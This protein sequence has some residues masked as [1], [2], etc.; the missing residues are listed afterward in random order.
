[1]PVFTPK[2]PRDQR[3]LLERDDVLFYQSA[4]LAAPLAVIG[5][6]SLDLTVASD[7][8]DTDIVAKLCVVETNGSVTCIIL[9]SLRCRYREGWDKRIPLQRGE[10]T[11]LRIRLAQLA[12]TFPCG[13]RIGLMITSSDFP[14]IQPHTNT[15][16]KPW[17]PAAPVVAHTR[18]LH[19]GGLSAALNLPVVR[20]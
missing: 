2:G 18:V 19:G 12:Y 14:R 8:A 5:D 16:A 9:G 20:L 13:V 11:R 10:P 15:M 4:P 17:E 1:M 7:V 6:V 3:H